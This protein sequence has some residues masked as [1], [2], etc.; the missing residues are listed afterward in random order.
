[1]PVSAL[2]ATLGEK[3]KESVKGEK[4]S[5]AKAMRYKMRYKTREPYSMPQDSPE[6]I[7]VDDDADEV[8][9]DGGGGA[10]GH[11]VIWCSLSGRDSA[12]CGYCDRI[13]IKK[14]A[15]ARRKA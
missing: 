7:L 10:L 14:S 6:I 4:P 12:E 11:P 13:F 9:C 15:A 8:K 5:D 3:R 2:N 1:L